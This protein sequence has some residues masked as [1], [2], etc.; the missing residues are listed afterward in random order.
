VR[1]ASILSAGIVPVRHCGDQARFLLLRCYRY[2][3]FP[4]GEV[5]HDEEPLTAARRELE[6]ETGL[7]QLE[8]RWGQQF[9][10]TERY[11]RGKVARYYIAEAPGGDVSLPVN[12]ELGRAEHD[13]FRWTS[14]AE[15]RG[16][17]NA[18]LL[19]VLDWA[20]T[21]VLRAPDQD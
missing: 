18:R 20:C 10:E 14:A 1:K 2:W 9:I 4:K 5:E 12:P 3:D 6:E 7:R 16:L 19:R 21:Q 17:L 8:F 13:E 15:A 11:G